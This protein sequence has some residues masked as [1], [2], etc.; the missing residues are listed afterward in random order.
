MKTWALAQLPCWLGGLGVR[1]AVRMAPVAYWASWA[2][3]L[4]MIRQRHPAIAEY[5]LHALGL[6]VGAEASVPGL[7]EARIARGI[8]VD[9][10]FSSC[11]EW[12]ALAGGSRPP[13][14][15]E[16]EPGASGMF[17]PAAGC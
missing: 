8:L 17:M 13:R 12:S 5:C 6:P 3:C 9:E 16:A 7:Q 1:C 11:P 15:E 2:D 10:G 14:S 4:P